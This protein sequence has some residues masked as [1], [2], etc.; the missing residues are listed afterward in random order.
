ML[1]LLNTKGAE[2]SSVLITTD[3]LYKAR[4]CCYT[5]TK[6]IGEGT[7]REGSKRKE[8]DRENVMYVQASET[9]EYSKRGHRGGVC[10]CGVV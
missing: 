10:A 3:E 1:L 6:E 9:P 4:G 2:K 5:N 7:G 8:R